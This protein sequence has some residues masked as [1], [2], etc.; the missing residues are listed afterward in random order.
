MR[1]VQVLYSYK[2]QGTNTYSQG[3]HKCLDLQYRGSANLDE[4]RRNEFIIF[5][6]LL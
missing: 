3:S 2:I 6:I 1:F 4:A 5:D